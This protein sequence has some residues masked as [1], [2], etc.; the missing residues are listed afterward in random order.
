MDDYYLTT[1]K[2]KC[3]DGEFSFHQAFIQECMPLAKADLEECVSAAA[4]PVLVLKEGWTGMMRD[5]T[6]SIFKCR[7]PDACPESS[8]E[9][10]VNCS[11][12]WTGPVCANCEENYALTAEGNCKMCDGTSARGVAVM[13]AAV[14][15]VIIGVLLVKRWYHLYE[16]VADMVEG[17]MELEVQAMSKILVAT[18]QIVGGLSAG[19]N[20]TFPVSFAMFIRNVVSVF[21]FGASSDAAYTASAA[22]SIAAY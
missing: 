18:L 2:P 4:G 19:L 17:I 11:K 10:G 16:T 1:N 22:I 15:L 8:T 7:N 6:Y 20:V 13:I 9:F 3:F 14:I 21:R 5:G 12:G